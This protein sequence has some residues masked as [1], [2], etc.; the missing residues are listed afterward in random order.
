M[1]MGPCVAAVAL[2]V[3]MAL[4]ALAGWEPLFN[5]KNLD[6]WT[7]CCKAADRNK[8]FWKAERGVIECDSLGRPGH[9]YVWLESEREFGNFQLRLKFQVFKAS[10]GNSGV[11]FRSRYADGWMDGPQVDIHAPQPLRT[12]VIYDETTGVR[13]WIWPSLANSA[14]DPAK[15]PEPARAT[16]LVYADEVPGA[17]NTL[18][19]IVDGM[20]VRTFVNGRRV[21]DFSAAGVLDDKVHGDR[22]VGT[23]GR[24]ALQLHC[25]DEL[26]IRF[27]DIQVRSMGE[28]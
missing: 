15:A 28:K 22:K 16:K 13:R 12:G 21:S 3:V 6:G 5:G 18:E 25:G 17:W 7:V 10:P 14:M 4:P 8:I 1:R 2:A 26:W 23:V 11:Q 27:K 19:L 20:K 24:I 9:D